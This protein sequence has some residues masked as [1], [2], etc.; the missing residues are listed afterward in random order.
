MRGVTAA[1]GDMRRNGG[2][3]ASERLHLA[4]VRCIADE[5]DRSLAQSTPLRKSSLRQQLADELELLAR[6]LRENDSTDDSC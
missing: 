6:A 5:F 1:S 3:S 2:R 4:T